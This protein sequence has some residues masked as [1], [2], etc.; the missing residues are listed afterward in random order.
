MFSIRRLPAQATGPLGRVFTEDF[1]D[2]FG[3]LRD[4]PVLPVIPR[5]ALRFRVVEHPDRYEIGIEAPGV[6]KEDMKLR[7]QEHSLIVEYAPQETVEK[8]DSSGSDGKV[9]LDEHTRIRAR[10]ELK[11]A[12]EL[13]DS[14]HEAS[15]ENGVLTVRLMKK[16]PVPPQAASRE[17]AI[18]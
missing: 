7:I 15:M 14:G 16:A 17:L 5:A 9:V 11:F 10:R 18:R 12:A 1:D 3:M 13:A 8:K 4:L 2:L 6:R